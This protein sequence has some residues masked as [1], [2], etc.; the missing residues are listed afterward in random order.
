MKILTS[1]GIKPFDYDKKTRII[2]MH[3]NFLPNQPGNDGDT[4]PKKYVPEPVYSRIWMVPLMYP[5]VRFKFNYVKEYWLS[6]LW[7][8]IFGRDKTAPPT[9]GVL[10]YVLFDIINKKKIQDSL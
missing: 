3:D 6:S 10:D 9:Y 8:D 2:D 1:K 7:A 5:F 4:K